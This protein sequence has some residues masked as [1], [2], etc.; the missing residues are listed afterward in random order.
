M[1]FGELMRRVLKNRGPEESSLADFLGL[2]PLVYKIWPPR[3]HGSVFC[4]SLLKPQTT[5]FR[6]LVRKV[7]VA[8]HCPEA[9]LQNLRQRT[10]LTAKVR[11][12]LASFTFLPYPPQ[13]LCS[14]HTHVLPDPTSSFPL[15]WKALPPSPLVRGLHILTDLTPSSLLRLAHH[16]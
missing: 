8:S 11:H 10:R 5:S 2:S 3:E 12:E 14:L 6:F 15:P 7:M 4:T 9:Q 16:R 1:L 13:D